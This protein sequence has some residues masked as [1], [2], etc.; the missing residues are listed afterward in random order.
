M[1][2][3]AARIPNSGNIARSPL[4]DWLGFDPFR[5]FVASTAGL[6]TGVEI[7]RTQTGFTVEIP[8]PGFK[9]EEIDVT[10]ED[11]VLTVAG[12]SAKRQFSRSLLL[13]EEI[14]PDS[15]SAKVEHGLLNLTLDVHP[16]AQPRKIAVQASS[17]QNSSN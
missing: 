13:P 9:P 8:V 12:K 16:K 3:M 2:D 6:A 5:N 11:N 17:P 10:L 7:T 4:S 15:I 1:A 14:N